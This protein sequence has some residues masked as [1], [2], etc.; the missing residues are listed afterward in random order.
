MNKS[1]AKLTKE[2]KRV[3]T[4]SIVDELD[5]MTH[6]FPMII[7]VLESQGVQTDMLKKVLSR[8]ISDA[9]KKV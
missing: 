4:E 2:Q 7:P 3:V 8:F 5:S 6:N 9:L 1:V